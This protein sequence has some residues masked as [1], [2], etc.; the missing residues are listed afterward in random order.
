MV[1]NFCLTNKTYFIA[2]VFVLLIATAFQFSISNASISIFINSKHNFFLDFAC[3]YGTYLGDGFFVIVACIILALVNKKHG[4]A[5]ALSYTISSLITQGLKHLLFD[6]R[7]RPTKILDVAQLHLVDGVQIHQYNSFPSGHTTAAFALFSMLAFL[8]N[9]PLYQI[10]FL[11]LAIFTAYTRIYLLQH[12]LQDT[13]VGSIIGVI[14][15][16]FIYFFMIK[17]IDKNKL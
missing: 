16:I 15:S 6:D 13:I 12:F 5:C 8:Y 11:A 9:K 10:L 3:K 7:N 14:T 4:I 17:R 2:Y 1:K